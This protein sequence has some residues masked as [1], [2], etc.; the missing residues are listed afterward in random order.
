MSLLTILPPLWLELLPL[1]ESN[2]KL[3]DV[4][5]KEEREPDNATLPRQISQILV[6]IVRN[7]ERWIAGY[8]FAINIYI[9]SLYLASSLRTQDIALFFLSFFL[10]IPHLSLRLFVSWFFFPS[11]LPLILSYLIYLLHS[12]LILFIFSTL[13]FSTLIFSTLIFST[14]IF[15]TLLFSSWRIT[16]LF[17]VLDPSSP[18]RVS[19]NEKIDKL[20]LK[21]DRLIHREEFE[22]AVDS[23]ESM[24]SVIL[25]NTK[26][27]KIQE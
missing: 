13:I 8:L 2:Q 6:S 21:A 5:F 22:K 4:N 20:M 15:S 25:L 12:Y 23:L 27:K 1:S 7:I 18:A 10:R 16:K 24:Y 9:S 14:L 17:L 11:T 26:S 3:L 19:S